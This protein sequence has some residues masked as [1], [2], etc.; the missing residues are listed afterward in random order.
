MFTKIALATD[1]ALTADSLIAFA[2]SLP[3]VSHSQ[4]ERITHLAPELNAEELSELKATL[5]A[6]P[7]EP[8]GS[9]ELLE[10]LGARQK[11]YVSDVKRENLQS[12]EAADQAVDHQAADA[13]FIN[14]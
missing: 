8:L 3:G 14:L 2:K 7:K 4:L 6:T 9:P 13:L 12:K 1:L 10:Q 11:E 5:E